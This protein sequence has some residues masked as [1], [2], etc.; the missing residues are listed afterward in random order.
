MSDTIEMQQGAHDQPPTDEP[1][2]REV[3]VSLKQGG[4]GRTLIARLVPY[5]EIAV[6][7]DGRGPYKERFLSGAFRAQLRAVHRVKA[8]VNYRHGQSI[9]DQIGSL[10]GVTDTPT[11]LDGE[12][13]IFNTPNGET[14]LEMF[15][16]GLDRIS[17]EFQSRR[18][19]IVE[20][21]VERL[22]AR[23]LGVALVP[24]GAYGGARVTGM[25]SGNQIEDDPIF[26]QPLDPILASML[27][28]YVTVPN[29]EQTLLRAFTEQPWD[30]SAS[31]WPDAE[32]YCSASA[33]DLNPSGQPKTKDMCH[34]PFREPGSG[35][36]N[37]NALRAALSRIGQGFPQ[38]AT[39][40][41][42]DTARAKLER[43]L[44]QFD[45]QN[46]ST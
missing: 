46:Q 3:P 31:R 40:M 13:Q 16:N 23:L 18:H 43:L 41:Q 4:N 12:L 17:I 19:R 5:N 29:L 6:V 8:F 30:G 39:Q 20:G 32:S 44:S 45:A 33:I 22:D 25:R 11:G 14:A 7:N 1:L 28:R 21:V 42:R 10:T 34:L 2:W 38:D 27:A 37:A 35:D 36:I 24:E 9:G 15:R 26:E